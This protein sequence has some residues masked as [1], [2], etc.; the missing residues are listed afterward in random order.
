MKFHFLFFWI[1]SFH[2]IC[3]CTEWTWL[4]EGAVIVSTP[5]DIALLDAR[6]GITMF[7]NV[8]V[9]VHNFTFTLFSYLLTLQLLT[10]IKFGYIYTFKI[11]WR[12]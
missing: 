12:Y 3:S 4:C 5:Q 9:L 8:N 6:R 7:K 10:T 11:V 2:L 1:V